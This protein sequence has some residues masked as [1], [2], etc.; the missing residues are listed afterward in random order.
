MYDKQPSPNNYTGNI[1][2]S[3]LSDPFRGRQLNSYWHQQATLDDLS[4][5]RKL[6]ETTAQR[7]KAKRAVIHSGLLETLAAHLTDFLEPKDKTL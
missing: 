7:F 5:W 4:Q 3:L 6:L 2:I 1:L